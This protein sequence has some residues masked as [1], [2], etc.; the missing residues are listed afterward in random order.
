[1]VNELVEEAS[2]ATPPLEYGDTFGANVE[3][4]QLDEERVCES[5]IANVV[6]G[7]VQEDKSS[8]NE[9]VKLSTD[10][11]AFQN[12][13]NDRARI[14]LAACDSIACASNGPSGEYRQ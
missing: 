6:R 11:T 9:S 4:E 7:T 10:S 2:T 13:R 3:G 5:V 8:N 12:I 14:R 1:M